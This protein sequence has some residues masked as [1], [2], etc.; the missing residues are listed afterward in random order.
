MSGVPSAEQVPAHVAIIMDG[1]GRWAGQRGLPRIEGHRRGV[2][3]VRRLVESLAG[4]SIRDLTL[5]AFSVENWQ[6]PPEEVEALMDLLVQFLRRE[7]RQLHKH[8]IRLRGIGRIHELPARVRELVAEVVGETAGYRDHALNL[9]LNYGSR[10]EVLDAT[11]AIA[12][13]LAAGRLAVPPETWEE[14][15]RYLYTG[16]LADPDLVIRT[17]GEWRL[18]N[19]LLLQGAYAELYF[20]EVPW[21]E[22]GPEHFQAALASYA[23]RERRFG[24]VQAPVLPVAPAEAV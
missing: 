5:F 20:C 10:A 14:Y 1:N 19:F 16:E 7:R 21:P 11:R 3:N 12:A 13:D 22:F 24:R 17:S 4:S 9:A 15:R 8:R 2:Q 6:R 23:R 18:S